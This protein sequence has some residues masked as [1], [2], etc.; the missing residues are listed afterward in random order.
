MDT[1]RDIDGDVYTSI[2]IGTQIWLVQNLKTTKYNDG[3]V[4][5][6]IIDN[7]AW[8]ELTTPGYCWY[9][10]DAATYKPTNG[11][12]YN[13]YAVNT[14]KLCP[15]GWHVPSDDEWKTLEISMGMTQGEVEKIGA[16]RG[17]D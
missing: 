9:N 4:I 17:T 2:T 11:A 16:W 10:N 15:L 14:S 3:E 1:I 8:T 12:L 13:W 7:T 6:N 5:P